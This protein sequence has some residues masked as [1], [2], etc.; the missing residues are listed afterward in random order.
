MRTHR[1]EHI[2]DGHNNDFER[3]TSHVR[4]TKKK[5]IAANV[6]ILRRKSISV[7]ELQRKRKMAALS[8]IYPTEGLRGPSARGA[9]YMWGLNN[10]I[11]FTC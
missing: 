7:S 1:I 8:N 11:F 4:K 5:K 6:S 3:K 10:V 9:R 2:C